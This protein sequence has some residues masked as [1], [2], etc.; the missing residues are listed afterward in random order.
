MFSHTKGTFKSACSIVVVGNGRTLGRE[1]GRQGHVCVRVLKRRGVSSASS[2]SARKGG[3]R[4]RAR[5]GR[6]PTS[7]APDLRAAVLRPWPRRARAG[8]N[9]GRVGLFGPGVRVGFGR[10]ASALE[11]PAARSRGPAVP[12]A[13]PRARRP[14]SGA[15]PP[16]KFPFWGR[17][18]GVR[19]WGSQG[20][21][22]LHRGLGRP[23]TETG[24]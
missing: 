9:A 17:G 18:L 20:P 2:G 12:L 10:G 14:A 3:R 6:G 24:V 23:R 1:R 11:R 15:R 16:V 5:T 13:S 19:T 4:L 7:L 21:L 22:A 8:V